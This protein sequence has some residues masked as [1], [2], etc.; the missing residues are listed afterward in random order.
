MSKP[1]TTLSNVYIFGQSFGGVN[2][3]VAIV[4]NDF[5]E[6]HAIAIEGAFYSY[7]TERRRVI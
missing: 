2:A 6:I 4:K 5:P 7:S 1:T 3:I